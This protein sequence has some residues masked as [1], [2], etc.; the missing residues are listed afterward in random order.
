MSKW[1]QQPAAGYW[2]VDRENMGRGCDI[3]G[4]QKNK[5]K[6]WN[7]FKNPEIFWMNN[8]AIIFHE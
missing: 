4:E 6:W 5:L 7:S 2:I 1:R 3:F 8:K